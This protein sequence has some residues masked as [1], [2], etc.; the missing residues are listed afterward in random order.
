MPNFMTTDQMLQNA[1]A[2]LADCDQRLEQLT[3]EK[4]NIQASITE[5]RKERASAES[6]V[7]K[8]TPRTRKPK[9]EPEVLDL[10]A[11]SDEM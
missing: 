3:A 9:A 11:E 8:L 10:A 5:V 4:K 6:A 1:Q 7:K 2:H